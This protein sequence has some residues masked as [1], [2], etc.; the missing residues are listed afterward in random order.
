MLASFPVSN[1]SHPSESITLALTHREQYWQ[2]EYQKGFPLLKGTRDYNPD[3]IENNFSLKHFLIRECVNCCH[4]NDLYIL[5][6][7]NIFLFCLCHLHNITSFFL[8]LDYT[9]NLNFQRKTLCF[10]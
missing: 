2:Q 8:K 4:L 9:L 1:V 6:W 3:S 5:S 10:Y 7:K